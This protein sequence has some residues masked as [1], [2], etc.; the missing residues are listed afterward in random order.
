MAESGDPASRRTVQEKLE[1]WQRDSNLA[2]VRV[3]EA[4]DRLPD[5]ERQDWRRLWDD[6]TTLLNKV[7]PTK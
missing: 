2:S 3:R 6:V 7:E 4:L 5:N 1:Y